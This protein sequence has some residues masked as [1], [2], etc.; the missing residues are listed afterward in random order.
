MAGLDVHKHFV[1]G[2]CDIDGSPGRNPSGNIGVAA[3]QQHQLLVLHQ[4][5]FQLFVF[6]ISGQAG[7]IHSAFQYQRFRVRGTV[8]VDFYFDEGVF[9]LNFGRI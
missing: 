5:V 6:W 4:N 1:S 2:F 9:F 3:G 7:E 8:L